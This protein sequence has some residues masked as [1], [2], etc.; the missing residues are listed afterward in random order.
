MK[1]YLVDTNV[2]V[3]LLI[4][5]N[6]DQYEKAAS[7]FESAATG[8]LKLL[9]LPVVIAEV[10]FVLESFY[11]R[12]RTEISESLE[13]ILSQQWLRVEQREV[14]T[15]LWPDYLSGLHFVDSFINTYR[16]IHEIELLSFDRRL[17]KKQ[18]N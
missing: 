15:E 4:R 3:R 10:C 16:Q 12:N 18:E 5:D 11:K 17:T 6:S 13:V 1:T 2:L 7:M 9:L 8:N 14:L